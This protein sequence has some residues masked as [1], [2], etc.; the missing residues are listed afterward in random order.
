MEPKQ[1]QPLNIKLGGKGNKGDLRSFLKFLGFLRSCHATSPWIILTVSALAEVTSRLREVYAGAFGIVTPSGKEALRNELRAVFTDHHKWLDG[2]MVGLHTHPGL[3]TT[4]ESSRFKSRA[5]PL[6]NEAHRFIEGLEEKALVQLDLLMSG[7]EAEGKF[8]DANQMIKAKMEAFGELLAV[9]GYMLP[10]LT[11]LGYTT[12]HMSARQTM[13][14]VV[15]VGGLYTEAQFER[16][17]SFHDFLGHFEH[18]VVNASYAGSPLSGGDHDKPIV[19]MMEGFV[20]ATE[21]GITVTF[22]SDNSDLT[23]VFLADSSWR[24]WCGQD[25]F[26]V[27]EED[28]G[29]ATA[30]FLK[31]LDPTHKIASMTRRE[32]ADL[33]L[34]IG[35]R[36][37]S[38]DAIRYAEEHNVRLIVHNLED[39]LEYVFEG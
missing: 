6:M 23:E 19:V 36:L 33:Q 26:D 14:G 17:P 22:G 27:P 13:V 5:H 8:F 1:R 3:L 29:I 39:G 31:V 12:C 9:R 16:E 15:P 11:A 25:H 10:P 2:V 21:D 34:S 18:L 35:S 24:W 37:V 38:P 7:I 20:G 4:E 28:H 30:R 32:L